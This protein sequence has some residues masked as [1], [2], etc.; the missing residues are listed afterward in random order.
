MNEIWPLF[1]LALAISSALLTVR[2]PFRSL[3]LPLKALTVL[4]LFVFYH[5]VP[6]HIVAAAEL[7]GL[8][9]AVSF[10]AITAVSALILTTVY[11][12]ARTPVGAAQPIPKETYL[13]RDSAVSPYLPASYVSAVVIICA[14]SWAVFFINSI[15]SFEFGWDGLNYHLPLAVRWL[16]EQSL[17]M[18]ESGQW[19]LSLPANGEIGMMMF[20]GAGLQRL[21]FA[22]N[23]LAFA[24]SCI[25]LYLLARRI[26]ESL[27]AAVLGVAL[28]AMVPIIQ[29]QAHSAYVDLYGT[30]FILAGIAIFAYRTE[31]GE[32]LPKSKWYLY[33]IAF[34]GLA[35]GIAM[36]TKHVYYAYAALCFAGAGTVIWLERDEQGRSPVALAAILAA[37]MLVPSVFWLLRAAFT[38]GNPLYPIEV[39][40]L[41]LTIFGGYAVDQFTGGI[42]GPTFVR[43]TLEWLYYPWVEFKLHGHS[44]GTGSGVGAAWAIFVPLGLFY[45]VVFV[46]RNFSSTQ[47]R[48]CAVLLVF[49]FVMLVL[50]W[51]ALRRLPRFGLPLI[52]I[53]CLLAVPLFDF[54]IRMRPKALGIL[55]ILAFGT[56]AVLSTSIPAHKLMGRI[57][58]NEWSRAAVFEIPA[59]LDTLPEGAVVWNT[60]VGMPINF[61][62]AG[63]SLTNRVIARPWPGTQP[64]LEFI[65]Q[66]GVDVVVEKHPFCCDELEKVGAR[67]VFEGR[68]GPTHRWRVWAVPE[69]D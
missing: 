66:Y 50:W 41:G 11:G 36:G 15:V 2:Q 18:P 39:N 63:E 52:S 59:L 58:A 17:A 37:C 69:P 64:A 19:N 65:R 3:S 29:F 6:I 38:T 14:G 31:P 46:A 32:H 56:T 21:A 28:F 54:L 9:D 10:P 1:A 34:A 43:S 47:A 12:F 57:R 22:F 67:P 30:S 53:G 24:I 48:T 23:L 68:V 8:I 33:A 60:V 62:L 35:W 27:H 7:A 25:S 5:L 61:S 16:Q 44:Y 42:I 51:F 45:A 49:I 13:A 40:I 20:L 26:T 4:V 55:L